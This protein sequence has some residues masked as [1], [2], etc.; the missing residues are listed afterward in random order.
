M[1]LSI[2][3]NLI[4]SNMS[5]SSPCVIGVGKHGDLAMNLNFIKLKT[6]KYGPGLLTTIE[7][8]YILN[9]NKKSTGIN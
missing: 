3:S 6:Q 4:T 9:Q 5:S 7:L 1:L 2:A 8:E